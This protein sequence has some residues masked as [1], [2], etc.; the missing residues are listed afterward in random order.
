MRT[1]IFTKQREAQ[2]VPSRPW[3]REEVPSPSTE[4]PAR[5]LHVHSGVNIEALCAHHSSALCSCDSVTDGLANSSLVLFGD[6]T[7]QQ[8]YLNLKEV[9]VH[10]LM[11]G[12]GDFIMRGPPI[13]RE[14]MFANDASDF[15]PSST[16]EVPQFG[17]FIY[18]LFFRCM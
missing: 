1:S 15:A 4:P 16:L 7:M 2:F 9:V 18:T 5:R 11:L 17:I 12:H 6:D 10:C 8:L 14:A 13:K 3:G